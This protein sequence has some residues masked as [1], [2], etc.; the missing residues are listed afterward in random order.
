MLDGHVDS[1]NASMASEFG[2][3]AIDFAEDEFHL[4][5]KFNFTS[6]INSLRILPHEKSRLKIPLC[7]M[8][9][10]S[11]VRPSLLTDVAKLEA[12]FLHGY[13]EGDRVFYV[14]TMNADGMSMDV[15]DDIKA[16]WDPLWI[17]ENESFETFLLSDPK[18]VKFSKKMFFVWDGNHR[19]QAWSKVILEKHSMDPLW[20]ISVDSI[21][22]DP[23]DQAG[24]L[25]DAMQC[26]N[27]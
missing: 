15:T 12:D 25:L 26:I 22:L 10:M 19:L 17:A 4:K 9:K 11:L 21:C 16:S 27:E 13:R 23:K 18:L 3:H 7:R 5:Q 1:S 14:S 20:H 8:T 24:P 6:L 2:E